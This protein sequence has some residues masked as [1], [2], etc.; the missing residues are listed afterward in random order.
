MIAGRMIQRSAGRSRPQGPSAHPVHGLVL[1]RQRLGSQGSP[2][3]PARHATPNALAA[4]SALQRRR[5]LVRSSA[6]V[7]ARQSGV[8][9]GLSTGGTL[10]AG[11]VS[12]TSGVRMAIRSSSEPA[13]SSPPATITR[14]WVSLFDMALR[15]SGCMVC[16]VCGAVLR[17]TRW[18]H[19]FVAAHLSRVQ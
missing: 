13:S 15:P 14:I 5:W 2:G 16:W 8:L 7:V 17:P 11:G 1:C 19:A 3:A 4:L 12:S 10:L 6:L 9:P 18:C